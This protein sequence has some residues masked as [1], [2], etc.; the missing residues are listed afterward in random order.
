MNKFC[1]GPQGGGGH[2]KE[3][4]QLIT[5]LLLFPFSSHTKKGEL[6]LFLNDINLA[7]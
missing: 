3:L 2:K 6:Y 1:Y 7:T 4:A 5:L